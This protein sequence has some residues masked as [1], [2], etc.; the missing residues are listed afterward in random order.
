MK[1]VVFFTM[2]L[3][4]FFSLNSRA[5]IARRSSRVPSMGINYGLLGD[6]LPPPEQAVALI[7]SLGF[8][9]VK[10]FDSDPNILNALAN[11][12]LRVVMAATNEELETLAASPAAAAEWLDQQVRP[13]LPAARIRMIT[14][15]NELLSHPEINQPRWPLLLPAMQNVQ[16]ALQAAGL[17]HQIKVSTCI[18][19]DA[20]NV[21]YPPSAARFRA[22]IADSVLRPV[23]QLLSSTKSYI[24]LNAY[25]YLAWSENSNDIP[26]DYAL[27]GPGATVVADG[28]LQYSDLLDAQVDSFVAAM[29]DLG[30]PGVKIAISETGWPTAGGPDEVGA[31]VSNAALY[32]GRLVKK[33]MSNPPKGT[34]K[35][36]GVSIPTFIFALFNENQKPGPVTERNWGLLYPNASHVYPLNF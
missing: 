5:E 30:L 8:G 23:L 12:S 14:V 4:L 3:L 6:D 16:E 34:P 28:D 24:F 21:S 26:L 15:G 2:L 33:M 31:S 25:P 20:L 1:G 10:I 13:H 19:M 7:K 9:Q 35:R 32:N 11:T 36:P 17:N 18:A 27:F 29:E 22:D